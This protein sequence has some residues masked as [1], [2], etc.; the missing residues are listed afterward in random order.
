[1]PAPRVRLALREGEGSRETAGPPW[2]V[3]KR[4]SGWSQCLRSLLWWFGLAVARRLLGEA[5]SH[6]APTLS[7]WPW[8][9]DQAG[10]AVRGVGC[11]C[12]EAG[13]VRAEGWASGCLGCRLRLPKPRLPA[14]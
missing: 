8:E 12:R 3:D 2:L 13:G 4:V 10:P 14:L 5:L 6:L 11:G 7:W 1:M 9:V